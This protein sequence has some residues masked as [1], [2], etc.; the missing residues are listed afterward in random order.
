MQ[1]CINSICLVTY[2]PK[3]NDCDGPW[4]LSPR[5]F[6][7]DGIFQQMMAMFWVLAWPASDVYNGAI[8]RYHFGQADVGYLSLLLQSLL[9]SDNHWLL[10]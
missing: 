9:Q 10:A 3:Q 5:D 1:V 7:G 8:L 2:C 6:I 4:E